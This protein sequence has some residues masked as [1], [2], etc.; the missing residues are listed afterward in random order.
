MDP[1]HNIGSPRDRFERSAS[2]LPDPIRFGSDYSTRP[3]AGQQEIPGMRAAGYCEA[4]AS[5][6]D[7]ELSI[8]EDV[9]NA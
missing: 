5:S 1:T 8:R 3:M 2:R 7:T 4:P 6:L 9:P